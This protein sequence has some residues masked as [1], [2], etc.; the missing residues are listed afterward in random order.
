MMPVGPTPLPEHLYAARSGNRARLW[1]FFVRA[2]VGIA[3]L[4]MFAIFLSV[5]FYRTPFG[6]TIASTFG[7]VLPL[8]AARVGSHVILYRDYVRARDGWVR[9]AEAESTGKEVDYTQVNAHVIDRLI[10]HAM[11]QQIAEE[12]GVTISDQEIEAAFQQMAES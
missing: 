4:L 1:H 11:V 12:V 7:R 2:A 9:Y 3:V 6:E 5:L 8:P 10:E